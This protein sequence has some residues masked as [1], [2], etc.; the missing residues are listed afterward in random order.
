MARDVSDAVRG[1]A[2]EIERYLEQHPNA[3]D[4]AEGIQRW[5]LSKALAATQFADVQAACERLV[6]GGLLRKE[7]VPD[8]RAIYRATRKS[9]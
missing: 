3:A 4:S 5:W 7:V 2:Q 1:I 6:R 8:G 9:I